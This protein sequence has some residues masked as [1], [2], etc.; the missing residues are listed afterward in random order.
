MV[1]VTIYTTGPGCFGC[2]KT[3]ELFDAAGVTHT[4]VNIRENDA[5]REY[6]TEDLGYMQAPIVVVEDGEGHDHWSG[7]QPGEI[8]RVIKL[9]SVT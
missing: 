6:V 9:V 2:K 8:E 1:Q 7:L 5:A 4:I 3:I